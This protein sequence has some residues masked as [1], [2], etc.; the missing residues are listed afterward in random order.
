MGKS[1]LVYSQN[2]SE[3]FEICCYPKTRI[4]KLATYLLAV[5]QLD[6]GG[7][8]T[9]E[10]AKNFQIEHDNEQVMQFGR[11]ENGAYTLDFCTPV[12]AVQAFGIA[13][14]SITQRLK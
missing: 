14:A 2:C 13:L 12:S 10:S 9:Q 6:F 1:R 11:I 3:D 8:V 4:K 5:F 7:R